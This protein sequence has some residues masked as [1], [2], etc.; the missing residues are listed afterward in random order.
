M[1]KK[2]SK[3]ATPSAS[4]VQV[5]Q[6]PTQMTN[7]TGFSDNITLPDQR[8]YVLESDIT[9]AQNHVQVVESNSSF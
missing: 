4:A 5:V 3:N 7:I 1:T 2:D 8:V 9:D 6:A